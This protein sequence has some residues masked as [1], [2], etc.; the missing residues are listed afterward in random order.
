MIM[1]E[2]GTSIRRAT[3]DFFKHAGIS[4]ALA[5]ESND[6]YFMK[7]MIERG[8]GISLLPVWAVRDEVEKGKLARLEIAGQCLRRS[9]AMIS[10]GRF[11]PAPTRAFLAFMLRHKA[12]LQKMALAAIGE[13]FA[14]GNETAKIAEPA[15]L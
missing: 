9:V 5:L 7:L 15:K 4:P 2:R 3:E 12:E 8:L 1:F 10:L 11:Q 13:P 14:A 6:T